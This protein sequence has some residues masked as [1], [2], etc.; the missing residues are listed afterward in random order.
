MSDIL[1]K[2][3][4]VTILIISSVTFFM[5]GLVWS[6]SGIEK[7]ALEMQAELSFSH[8]DVYRKL[9]SEI[10]DG[11]IS[12]AESRLRQI[13]DEQKMLMAEFVQYTGDPEFDEY[14]NFRD[15]E[16]SSELKSYEI[17]WGK[18]WVLPDCDKDKM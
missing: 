5:L 8:Y 12:R 13:I 4:F 10:S 2:K 9:Q 3:V 17:D 1:V 11:C 16:L 7:A 14:V 6:N 18:I 15:P